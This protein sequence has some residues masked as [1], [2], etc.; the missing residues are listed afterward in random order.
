MKK[1]SSLLLFFII[2]ILSFNCFA[3]EIDSVDDG[4]DFVLSDN[5][6]RDYGKENVYCFSPSDG[7]DEVFWIGV[8][9]F[10]NNFWSYSMDFVDEEDFRIYWDNYFSENSLE[11]EWLEEHGLDVDVLN[12]YNNTSYEIHGG[13]TYYKY[14]Q[15]YSVNCNGFQ[16]PLE[17][18]S[19]AYSTVKN[20][21]SYDFYYNR[22]MSEPDRFNDIISLLENISYTNGEI[23][24]RINGETI[25]PDSA[26]VLIEGRTLVPIRAVAE[27]MGYTVSWDAENEIVTMT[28]PDFGIVLDFQIGFDTAFKNN[29]EEIALDVAPFIIENRTYL[30]LRAVAEAMDAT[31]N[32]NGDERCVEIYK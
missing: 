6:T 19:V 11:K 12:G 7:S 32:W 26:P 22:E 29:S 15:Y 13:V 17:Y 21:K 3:D 20:G 1:A 16:Q 30:P 31:V 8:T 24:I 9:D 23:K 25:Y 18:Y 5:W 2:V 28:Q 10:G 14:E 4:F 27:K